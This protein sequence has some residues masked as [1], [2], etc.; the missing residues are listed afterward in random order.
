MANLA[1]MAI[2]L[3]VLVPAL[4]L[5]ACDF[6]N[7]E[8]STPLPTPTTTPTPLP[9]TTPTP[10]PLPTQTAFPLIID[11]EPYPYAHPDATCGPFSSDGGIR[12]HFI[13]WTPDGSHLIFNPKD[14]YWPYDGG[15][16]KIASVEGFQDR[17]IVDANPDYE[18]KDGFHADLSPDGSTIVYSSCQFV[19]DQE[20]LA[21]LLTPTELKDKGKYIDRWGPLREYEIATIDVDGSVPRRLTNNNRIENYP[22]WSPDGTQIV[23]LSTEESRLGSDIFIAHML[24][25][26]NADGSNVR[27]IASTE[28]IDAIRH[29]AP[30]PPVWSP[31]GQWLTFLAYESIPGEE[32]ILYVIRP[33]GT[34][35]R[36]IADVTGPASWSPDSERL[37]FAKIE[38]EYSSLYVSDP[39]GAD[40]QPVTPSGNTT[41]PNST[42][43]QVYWS[44]DGSEILFIASEEN[45]HDLF[46]RSWQVPPIASLYLIRPDGSKLRTLADELRIS[47]GYGLSYTVAAWSPDSSQ[48]AVRDDWKYAFEIFVISRDGSETVTVDSFER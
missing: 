40:A 19:I 16:I 33:D 10:M 47:R 4:V 45:V 22:A 48:I 31:D 41:M 12:S 3:A 32:K 43:S 36:R 27:E 1:Y 2:A 23:F 24:Y 38:G 13:Y 11:M 39:Y 30:S 25:I 6:Q 5:S 34:D 42:I 7:Y 35:L 17:T 8:P 28:R 9:T 21:E 15:I 37:V 14:P 18:F 26:V 20:L 44:P 46:H 29:F